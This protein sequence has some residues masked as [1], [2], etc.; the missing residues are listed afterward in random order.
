MEKKG[1]WVNMGKT[2]YVVS[3]TDLDLLE[4]SGKDPC[5]VCLTGECNHAIV[6]GGCLCRLHKKCSGIKGPCA[7]TLTSVC[8]MPGNGTAY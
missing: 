6:C 8:P 4:K 7:L 1:L 5:V 2:K 3:G